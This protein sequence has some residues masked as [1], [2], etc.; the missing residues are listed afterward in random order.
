MSADSFFGIVFKNL[1]EDDY[2]QLLQYTMALRSF[3]SLHL[4]RCRRWLH[5]PFELEVAGSTLFV[6]LT[7]DDVLKQLT[8]DLVVRLF[9]EAEVL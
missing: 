4:H 6:A 5:H 9:V 3:A 8:E 2:D 7:I 1:F